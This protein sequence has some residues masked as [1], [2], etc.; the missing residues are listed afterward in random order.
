MDLVAAAVLVIVAG[1]SIWSWRLAPAKEAADQFIGIWR[2]RPWGKQF[3]AD[4]F[5]LLI[6]L[7]LWMLAD[8][9]NRGSWLLA[10]LCVAAMPVFGAMSAAVYWL[11]R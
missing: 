9:A 3:Y 5:G 11:L 10:V 7:A 6:M 1:V 4:F 2:V 8:A